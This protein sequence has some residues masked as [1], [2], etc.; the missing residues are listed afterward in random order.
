MKWIRFEEVPG[1]NGKTRRWNVLTVD[2]GVCLGVVKWHGAWRKYAFF[3]TPQTLFEE[4]CLRDIAQALAE[5]TA[6]VRATWR[7]RTVGP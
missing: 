5:A 1:T 6:A 2:G 7:Q 3:P 4:D